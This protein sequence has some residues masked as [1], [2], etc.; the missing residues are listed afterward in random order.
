MRLPWPPPHEF[1]CSQWQ[2]NPTIFTRDP[3][4]LTMGLYI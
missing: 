2:Q 1:V 3:T 4:Q